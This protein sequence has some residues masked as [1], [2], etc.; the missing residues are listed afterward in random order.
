[1]SSGNESENE[2]ILSLAQRL[3]RKVLGM[4]KIR[5]GPTV[6]S[7][8]ADHMMPI[9]WLIMLAVMQSIGSRRGL[10]DVVA[11]GTRIP[12]VGLQ[13][14]KFMAFDGTWTE[15]MFQIASISKSP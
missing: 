1:M 3:K 7:G 15:V 4:V 5:M 12:N 9:G 10:H 2:K 8:A 11:D 6:N 13:L 14:V